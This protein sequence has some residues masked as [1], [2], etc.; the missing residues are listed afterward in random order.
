MCGFDGRLGRN[1]VAIEAAHAR[2]HSQDGPGQRGR[3]VLAAPC[4]LRLRHP[5]PQPEPADPLSSTHPKRPVQRP[6]SYSFP[7]AD[8]WSLGG[9]WEA[10]SAARKVQ[11]SRWLTQ[12]WT[13]ATA[14]V[15]FTASGNVFS[16]RKFGPYRRKAGK[17]SL[18]IRHSPGRATLRSIDAGVD[19]ASPSSPRSPQKTHEAPLPH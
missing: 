7:L 10:R 12:T 15:L 13:S 1:P 16:E 2:W 5:Q 18:A 8:R 17:Y 14:S 6:I 19:A 3:A 11:R 9:I 4:P